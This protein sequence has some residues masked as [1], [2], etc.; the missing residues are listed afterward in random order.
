MKIELI[1]FSLLLSFLLI[2][3]SSKELTQKVDVRL[4]D[5]WALES[6][7]GEA[8]KKAKTDISHPLIEIYVEESRAQGTTNCNTLNCK[9]EIEGDKIL[10]VNI[11][12]TEMNCSGDIEKR[13]L[14]ALESI[15][16]YKIEKGRLFLRINF[17]K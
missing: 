8:Y 2:G 16:N 10:F 7:D 4:H 12:V 15:T 13:F 6:I 3:C 14:S 5:I 9:L 17:V 11:S 1:L